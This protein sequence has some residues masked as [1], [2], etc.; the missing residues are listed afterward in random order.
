MPEPSLY[1]LS[2]V[3]LNL[4]WAP[5]GSLCEREPSH[6][7]HCHASDVQVIGVLERK[8]DNPNSLWYMVEGRIQMIQ[9]TASGRE[10]L[11]AFHMP[12][13]TFCVAAILLGRPFPCRAVATVDSTVIEVPASRFKSLFDELPDFARRLLA[14]MAPRLCESHCDCAMSV[15]AVDKR[16]ASVLL[17]LDKQFDGGIIPFTREE[18]AKMVGTTGETCTRVLSEWIRQG[19]IEGR[20]GK[21]RLI[22][23]DALQDASGSPRTGLG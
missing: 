18:I 3:R 13:E 22:D 2:P 21:V 14:E 11:S 7:V 10:V 12:G 8:D 19:V 6:G 23:R 1:V 16:L 9:T 15:E 4:A 17:R 20:R 5:V